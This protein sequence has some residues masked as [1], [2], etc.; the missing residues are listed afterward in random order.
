MRKG[1]F[2][3]RSGGNVEF[4]VNNPAGQRER[5]VAAG[6]SADGRKPQ[7]YQPVNT[8]NSFHN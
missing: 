5:N 3:G 4:G 6:R 8:I 1:I 2:Y 7:H